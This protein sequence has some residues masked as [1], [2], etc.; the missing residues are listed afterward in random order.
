MTIPSIWH[1]G[2]EGEQYQTNTDQEWP[3]GTLMIFQDGRKFR[4]ALNGGV[5]MTPG[6]LYASED[7]IA[8][9]IANAV[10]AATAAGATSIPITLGATASTADQY[11]EGY[12]IIEDDA[13]EGF[14]YKIDPHLAVASAGTFTVFARLRN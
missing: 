7:T 5:T 12:I 8:N 13:G 1:I 11:K 2:L 3:L 10:Q 14:V 4:Y 6:F 9:H